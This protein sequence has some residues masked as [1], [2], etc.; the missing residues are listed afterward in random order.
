MCFQIKRQR[1]E[2]PAR[3]GDN[4]NY[5]L[6]LI[7][8]S[9]PLPLLDVALSH[10]LLDALS[11]DILL[12]KKRKTFSKRNLG[13]HCRIRRK[14]PS[15]FKASCSKTTKRSMVS[16]ILHVSKGRTAAKKSMASHSSLLLRFEGAFGCYLLGSNTYTILNY[17]L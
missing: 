9:S 14:N 2:A 17:L 15:G 3:T 12:F 5:S 8:P 16:Q 4:P 7:S 10:W 11:S 13:H 6:A 1:T